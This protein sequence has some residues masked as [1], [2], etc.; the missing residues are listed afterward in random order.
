[1]LG[2]LVERFG[3]YLLVIWL[4]R[5]FNR[6]RFFLIFFFYELWLLFI[7]KRNEGEYINVNR[8]VLGEYV[9]M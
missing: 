5:L 8:D 9:L 4:G 6:L 7:V 2:N 3:L 1:M